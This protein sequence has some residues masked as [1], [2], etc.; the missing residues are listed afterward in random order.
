MRRN[1]Q[2]NQLGICSP[3]LRGDVSAWSLPPLSAGIYVRQ[4]DLIIH[5]VPLQWN[6]GYD[7]AKPLGV[8]N[9]SS[10][11]YSFCVGSNRMKQGNIQQRSEKSEKI[12]LIS[13]MRSAIR[14]SNLQ[15]TFVILDFAFLWKCLASSRPFRKTSFSPLFS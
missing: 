10:P 3:V 12:Q 11:V 15:K 8:Q 7:Q 2:I 13:S 1:G 9:Y 5:H 6:S 14:A 4:A